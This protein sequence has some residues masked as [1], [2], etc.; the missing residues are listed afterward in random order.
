M[1]KDVPRSFPAAQS[2][3][4]LVLQPQ[5]TRPLYIL[6]LP[7]QNRQ[8]RRRRRL[9]LTYSSAAMATGKPVSQEST[10]LCITSSSTWPFPL[11]TQFFLR[12]IRT[13]RHSR[14]QHEWYLCQHPSGCAEI[15]C[16]T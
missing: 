11:L 4:P 2:P 12:M 7:H 5:C 3:P 15:F 14:C 9:S 1:D 8:S 10:F 13:S 6:I 16:A